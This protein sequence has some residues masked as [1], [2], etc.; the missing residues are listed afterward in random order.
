MVH[1]IIIAAM[2]TLVG[3]N[4]SGGQVPVPAPPA[5]AT[6]PKS[7]PNYP[8]EGFLGSL[9]LCPSEYKVIREPA[10]KRQWMPL[11]GQHPPTE[12]PPGK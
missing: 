1:G 8:C 11:P 7:H 4:G 5:Q 2:L 9:V 3:D 6:V 12:P 10:P